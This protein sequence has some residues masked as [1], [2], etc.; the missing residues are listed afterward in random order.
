MPQ[1]LTA[2]EAGKYQLAWGNFSN[3]NAAVLATQFSPTGSNYYKVNDAA[4]NADFA[5]EYATTDPGTQAA[6]AAAAQQRILQQAYSV[7]VFQLTTALA[8]SGK[9]HGV[10]FGADARLA[11]LTDAWV[12]E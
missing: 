4:L 10:K 6:A 12:G 3:A 2:L 9:V 11:Q 7:P 1:Y 5:Q 8:T